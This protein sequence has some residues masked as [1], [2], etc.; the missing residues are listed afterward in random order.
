VLHLLYARF[1]HK[2]L[3]DL[4]HLNT[5]EP[6]QKLVNQGLILAEDG[7]KMSKSLGNVVNPDDVVNDYGADAL[8]LYEM[9]MGPLEQTKPWSTKGVDGVARFLGR[10]WRLAFKQNQEG[11]WELSDKLAEGASEDKKIRKVVHETVKKVGEDIERMAFNTG[12]SQMMVCTNELTSAEQ[13]HVDDLVKLLQVL[14]P[15]APHLTEE[16]YAG[17]KQRF[18]DLSDELLSE[19]DWPSFVAE[20]LVDDEIELAVQVN[21]KLRAKLM[22][23]PDAAK[24]AIEAAAMETEQVQKFIEGKT[25]RKVIVVPKRLV[26]IVAN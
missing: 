2:V 15:Y 23:S 3:F 13:V 6:F 14:N 20:Y 8:R 16:V 21:G 22:V 4:G 17:L 9:F 24:D 7:R 26:N 1:W 19:Q 10:V 25:V 12:I 11:V 5:V 18:E